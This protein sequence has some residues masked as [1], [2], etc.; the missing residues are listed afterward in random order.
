MVKHTCLVLVS[1]MALF[2]CMADTEDIEEIDREAAIE[3]T[4]EILRGLKTRFEEH[5][6]VTYDNEALEAAAELAAKHIN[7]RKLPDKAIDVI[8]EAGAN[9]RGDRTGAAESERERGVVEIDAIARRLNVIERTTRQQVREGI[10][11]AH[12]SSII[13]AGT[14]PSRR[15]TSDVA[16]RT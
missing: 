6:A 15:S 10:G 7:D 14:V 9:L 5:H 13:N 11:V 4:V 2:S 8:D 16:S 3:E 12:Q 1:T